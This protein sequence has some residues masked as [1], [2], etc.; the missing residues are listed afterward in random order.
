MKKL[1][2]TLFVLV[3]L[4]SFSFAQQNTAV[5]QGAKALELSKTSGE[6]VFTLPSNLTNRE[7]QDNAKYYTHYFTVDF[8]EESHEAKIKMIENTSK[9]RFVIARFLTACKVSEVK[10]D[11][12]MVKITPFLNDYL[13]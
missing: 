13:K 3:G 2:Y 4:T 9:S 8:N 6:Y 10:V 11:S 1:M 5:S 12:E 7:V